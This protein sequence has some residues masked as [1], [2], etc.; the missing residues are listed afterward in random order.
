VREAADSTRAPAGVH[1]PDDRYIPIRTVDLLAG[2]MRDP[3]M[4]SVAPAIAEVGAALGRAV[5]AESRALAEHVDRAYAPFNPDRET[6][7]VGDLRGDLE[8]LDGAL[9]YTFDKANY[10]LL[11]DTQVRA[12]IDSAS[13]HGMKVRVDPDK[14]GALRIYVRGRTQETR[15][16]RTVRRPITGEMREVE[17]YRRL[18]IVFR[19]HDSAEV[20]IK[21]FREIPV[22][23]LEALLPHA[24]V[25]M[26]VLDRIWIVGGGVGAI[27]GATWKA[28]ALLVQGTLFASQYLWALS[29]GLLGLSVRSVL[30]YRRAKHV[31]SSQRLHHLYYQ[32]IANNAGVLALLVSSIRHEEIKE[33]LLAYAMLAADPGQITDADALGR[34]VEAWIA[35]R[36]HVRLHFDVTDA[37][38]SLDRFGLWEDRAALRTLA[39][40]DACARLLTLWRE[41]GTEDYHVASIARGA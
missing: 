39:P 12:A 35:A 33:T 11:E 2:L 37:L 17:L 18:A 40:A 41:N 5:H 30:G 7:T 28:V 24:E 10:D 26:S 25:G 36:F 23:D 13:I 3:A 34:A 38:E 16:I 4:E 31:R 8:M 14:V 15:L 6:V 20:S 27:G 1:L 32:N 21:L 29:V 9:D 19:M 22:A